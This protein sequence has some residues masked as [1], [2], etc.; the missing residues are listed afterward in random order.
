MIADC[1]HCWL[2]RQS[3]LTFD[4]RSCSR[5]WQTEKMLCEF[6]TVAIPMR[7]S[8]NKDRT[9]FVA[10]VRG[11]LIYASFETASSGSTLT[12]CSADSFNRSLRLKMSLLASLQ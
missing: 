4:R 9:G 6:P 7:P 12:V 8:L 10:E 1:W 5:H 11:K 3:F 2:M